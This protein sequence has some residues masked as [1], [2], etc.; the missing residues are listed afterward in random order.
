MFKAASD[1]QARDNKNLDPMG[2]QEWKVR[3]ESR[4]AL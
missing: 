1:F 3:I 2:K 4:N